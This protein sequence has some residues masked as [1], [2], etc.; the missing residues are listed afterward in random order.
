MQR[1]CA[2]QERCHQEVRTRLI[3]HQVYG[4]DLETVIS[5]LIQEGFL[6]ETRFAESYTSGK[7]RIK[8]WGRVKIKIELK[9]RSISAYN[10]KKGLA[11]IDESEYIDT[12]RSIIVKKRSELKGLSEYQRDQKVIAHAQRKGYEYSYIA[13]ILTDLRTE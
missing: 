12:L 10:I 8:K 4:D 5:D 3:E 2:Y 1:F 6:N 11:V 7:F 9:R 13:D